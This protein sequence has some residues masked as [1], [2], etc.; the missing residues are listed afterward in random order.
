MSASTNPF[1]LSGK[2][3]IVTGGA[4][5][6]GFGIAKRLLDAGA[7]VLIAD[8][9][10]AAA[11][12]AAKKLMAPN[13]KAGAIKADVTEEGVGDKIVNKCLELFGSVDI[14]V[15]NAGIY[16]MSPVLQMTPEFFERVYRINLKGLVFISKAVAAKMV[17]R[18]TGGKI[19]N[20]SSIDAFHPSMV[21]LAAYDTSKGGVLMFTKALALELAS[22]GIAVNAIAPGGIATEGAS[23]PMQGMTPEQTQQMM[24]GFISLIPLGRMG[25]PDDIGK[26][27]VF[28]ASSAS[29]YMT[30][31][32]LIVDGGRLLR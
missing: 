15:N 25:I 28:L 4:M 13:K 14:L 7:N 8:V 6:I 9:D 19:I 29:D 18:K 23:R 16:P 32:T 30:G 27:A 17:E 21:G 2:S 12:A 20:I 26:V 22:Y 1:D 11:E 5:G 24:K 31:Q 10:G 3:A